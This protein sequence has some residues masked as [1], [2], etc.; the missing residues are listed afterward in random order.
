MLP[1]KNCQGEA[2]E[3]SPSPSARHPSFHRMNREVRSIPSSNPSRLH[4]LEILVL[5]VR[6]IE[7]LRQK[8]LPGKESR[9]SPPLLW[10]ELSILSAPPSFCTLYTDRTPSGYVL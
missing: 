2:D 4:F 7:V 10:L 9:P 1:P 3:M 6:V 5:Y 8:S